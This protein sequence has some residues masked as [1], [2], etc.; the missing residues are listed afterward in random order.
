MRGNGEGWQVN[1][2]AIAR[3]TRIVLID[4]KGGEITLEA[5]GDASLLILSGEPMTS[6]W[7]CTA[8]SS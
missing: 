7:S 4:R 5:N 6:R 8:L 3:E 2:N 1:G